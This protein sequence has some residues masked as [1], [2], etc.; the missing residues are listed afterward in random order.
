MTAV[1]PAAAGPL[2][3]GAGWAAGSAPWTFSGMMAG[4]HAG[5]PQLMPGASSIPMQHMAGGTALA[6]AA[7]WAGAPISAVPAAAGLQATGAAPV[8]VTSGAAVSPKPSGLSLAAAPPAAAAG[9]GSAS[10]SNKHVRD[11]AAAAHHAGLAAEL[12]NSSKS[13]GAACIADM[14]RSGSLDSGIL[15]VDDFNLFTTSDDL[16]SLPGM[17][18]GLDGLSGLENLVC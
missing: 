15:E 17:L 9:C 5:M 8:A 7:N 4:W 16:A 12:V 13:S 6:M 14:C 18:L 10:T 1:L 3:P 11:A 2:L